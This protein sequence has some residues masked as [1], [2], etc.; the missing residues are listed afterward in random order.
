MIR[1]ARNKNFAEWIDITCFGQIVTNVKTEGKAM[2]VARQVK[3]E[4]RKR[5]LQKLE[6]VN[7]LE[8]S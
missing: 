6:I 3:R 5:Y 1:I 2:K 4:A 7:D 8:E